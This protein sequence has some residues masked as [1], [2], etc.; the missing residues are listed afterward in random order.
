MI[1]KEEDYSENVLAIEEPALK[2]TEMEAVEEQSKQE[3]KT[4][5]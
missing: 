3:E 4:G 5:V 1:E 2:G